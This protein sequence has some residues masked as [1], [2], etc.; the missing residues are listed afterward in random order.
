MSINKES[1]R[2]YSDKM[3]KSVCKDVGGSQTPNSGAGTFAKGDVVVKDASLLIE[4]KTVI[5]DKKSFS[6]KKD[7]FEKNKEEA[8]R[9]RLRNNCVAFNFG[10]NQQNYYV[11]DSDLMKILVEK[12]KEIDD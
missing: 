4:C 1:T 2:F 8:F 9:Q 3:E 6:I 5:E 12:L 10:P 7:W 11:I